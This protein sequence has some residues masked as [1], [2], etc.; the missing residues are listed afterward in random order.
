MLASLGTQAV[1]L[2][3]REVRLPF[4]PSDRSEPA[5]RFLASLVDTTVEVDHGVQVFTLTAEASAA[6]RVNAIPAAADDVGPSVDSP[7]VPTAGVTPAA[8][9]IEDG[10]DAV[11]LARAYERIAL[12]LATPDASLTALADDF[13]KPVAVGEQF[14]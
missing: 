8:P 4:V 12:E 7:A 2:G 11:L 9:A 14:W 5:R 10:G 3:L 1:A 6:A 13:E